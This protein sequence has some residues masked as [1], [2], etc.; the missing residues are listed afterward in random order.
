M[1]KRS[2]VPAPN[3]ERERIEEA[4]LD[5]LKQAASQGWVDIATG[6]CVDVEDDRLEAFIGQLGRQ[7]CTRM[8]GADA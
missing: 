3:E 2:D 6:R 1:T 5:A 7:R 4:K 8:T